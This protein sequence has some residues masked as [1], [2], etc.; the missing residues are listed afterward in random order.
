VSHFP[1]VE[2]SPISWIVAAGALIPSRLA[3]N[4]H[5]ATRKCKE[6]EGGK[7]VDSGKWIRRAVVGG[8][9]SVKKNS[10]KNLRFENRMRFA[11]T[12]SIQK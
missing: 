11:R 8:P 3:G 5:G 2:K 1:S 6:A 9:W 12:R 10:E 7:A 4:I